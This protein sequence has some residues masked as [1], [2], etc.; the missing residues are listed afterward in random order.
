MTRPTISSQ[1]PLAF[2]LATLA[3]VCLHFVFH[4]CPNVVTA[5]FAP[6][7][8]SLWEHVKLIYWPYLAAMLA[9]T[10]G[11]QR[12]AR[13][14]WLLTL[15]LLIVALEAV[16]YVFHI[17]LF[18]DSLIFDIALYLV[19]MA[20]GFWLP[21]RL[22]TRVSGRLPTPVLAVLTLLLGCLLVLF[23]FLPPD[24]ILF[25]DLSGINTWYTIPY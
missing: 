6:V 16:S 18:R 1:R 12:R 9:V 21:G 23:T 5:I 15:L 4:L 14:S 24:R 20:A 22:E 8:E 19:L 25:V 3:G 10:R 7:C 11:A 17:V 13:G 2:V